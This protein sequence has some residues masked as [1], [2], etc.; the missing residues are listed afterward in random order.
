MAQGTPPKIVVVNGYAVLQ[1]VNPTKTYSSL[2]TVGDATIGGTLSIPGITG[3]G[4]IGGTLTTTGLLTATSGIMLGTSPSVLSNYTEASITGDWTGGIDVPGYTIRMTRIGRMVYINMYTEVGGFPAGGAD[5][6]R[7]NTALPVA[8]RPSVA[9]VCY[10]SVQENG[11]ILMG[12][13]TIGTDGII[14][15]G[16]GITSTPFNNLGLNALGF[17]AIEYSI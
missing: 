8:F 17:P 1:P 11:A 13:I 3:T 5:L 2:G 14:T 7:F 15:G 16:I 6:I 4:A 12:L 10:C 9:R